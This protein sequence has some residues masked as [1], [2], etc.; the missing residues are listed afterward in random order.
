MKLNRYATYA[1]GVLGYN[2]L[3]ILWGAYVRATGS[4]AGCG[5]HWPLCDGQVIPRAPAIEQIIEFSH[6]LSSGPAPLLVVGLLVWAFRAYPKGHIVR[7]GATFSM[8]IIIVEALPGAGLVL[9]QLKWAT[10]PR[11]AAR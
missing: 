2:M 1:P 10:T 9:L 4:G 7:L 8:A 3:A 11:W 6:R 5:A